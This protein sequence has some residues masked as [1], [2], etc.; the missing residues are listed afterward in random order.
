MHLARFTTGERTGYGLLEDGR[1][2]VLAGDPFAGGGAALAP[3][4]EVLSLD[5]VRLLAPVAPTKVICVGLNYHTH[6]REFGMAPPE[7][8]LLFMKPPSAVIGPGDVTA[9]DLQQR[10]GQWTRAKGF[11]TFAPLGPAIATDLDPAALRITTHV[12]GQVRQDDN[13]A[14]MI[15]PVA[16]LVSSISGIMT[17]APGDVVFTGTPSGIGPLAPGDR[18]EVAIEGIGRLANPVRADG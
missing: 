15:F 1:V 17:L 7:V 6:A 10:D 14:N 12:N 4:G 2:R 8:P 9:R 5:A 18:V 13:T 16:D 11:D 3:T